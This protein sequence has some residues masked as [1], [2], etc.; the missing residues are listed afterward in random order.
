MSGGGSS[1][2][3][4][5]QEN[6]R[7]SEEDKEADGGKACCITENTLQQEGLALSVKD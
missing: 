5:E 2:S 4:K 7:E 6:G 1:A 3:G